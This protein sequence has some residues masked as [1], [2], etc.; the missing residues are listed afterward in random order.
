MNPSEIL[1]AAKALIPTEAEWWHDGYPYVD[2]KLCPITAI[3]KV[4]C[5]HIASAAIVLST[6]TKAIGGHKIELWND[7]PTR[8]YAEIMVAFDIAIAAVLAKESSK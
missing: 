4:G 8:T 7:D 5:K 1:I 6:F 2:G 3:H